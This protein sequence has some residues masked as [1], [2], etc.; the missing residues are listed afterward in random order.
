V[1]A[2][3]VAREGALRV[4]SLSSNLGA[5]SAT[6]TMSDLESIT[7]RIER[8]APEDLAQFRTWFAEFDARRWDARIEADVRAGKLDALVAEALAEHRAGRTEDL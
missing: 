5:H 4:L 1:T 2:A 8:L 3:D 6:F 7:G